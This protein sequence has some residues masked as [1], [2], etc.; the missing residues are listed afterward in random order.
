MND[1][2]KTKEQFIDELVKIRQKLSELEESEIERKQIG[3]SLT[4]S[5]QRFRTLVETIPHGVQENDTKGIITFSNPAHSKMH[6]YKEEELVGK[7]IWEM[8]ASEE[9]REELRQ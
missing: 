3:E 6:G 9:G 8:L 2:N 5:E 4:Q 7:A 1:E